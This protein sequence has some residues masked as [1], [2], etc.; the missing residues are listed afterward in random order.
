MIK[1][2]SKY[3]AVTSFFSLLFSFLFVFRHY[4]TQQRHPMTIRVSSLDS[5]TSSGAESLRA[6]LRA[7][8]YGCVSLW[9]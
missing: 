4:V 6:S 1:K 3:G 7:F 8:L 5:L 2:D 9:I